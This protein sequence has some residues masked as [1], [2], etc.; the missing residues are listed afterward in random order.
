MD[1]LP[2]EP[3]PKVG[4]P[5]ILDYAQPCAPRRHGT[6]IYLR[7]LGFV[8]SFVAILIAIPFG[9]GGIAMV[10]GWETGTD[11]ADGGDGLGLVIVSGILLAAG[12]WVA[13]RAFRTER[14]S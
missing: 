13:F 10:W 6:R 7:I 9:C 5:P 2:L 4:P 11:T 8:V 14:P 3:E 1:Y 12:I